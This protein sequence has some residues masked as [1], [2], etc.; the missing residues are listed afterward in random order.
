MIKI[1]FMTKQYS[2]YGNS[3]CEKSAFIKFSARRLR[4]VVILID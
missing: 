2:S 4:V 3:I 1:P